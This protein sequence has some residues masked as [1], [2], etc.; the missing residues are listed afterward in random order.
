MTTSSRVH[1]ALAILGFLTMGC[2]SNPGTDAGMTGNDTGVP[3][4]ARNTGS[5]TGAMFDSGTDSGVS[6]DAGNDAGMSATPLASALRASDRAQCVCAA[7]PE[8]ATADVCANAVFGAVAGDPCY[9]M[10]AATIGGAIQTWWNCNRDAANALATCLTAAGA[11]A[12][13]DACYTAAE[14]AIAACGTEP[15]LAAYQTALDA[16][17]VTR[18][19]GTGADTCSATATPSS[20]VGMG[21]FTGTTL[22]RGA[23]A[24]ASCGAGE[25]G[26]SVTHRW[27]APADGEY[28]IDTAGS[29]FDTVLIVADGCGAAAKELGC[30]DDD[31][32]DSLLSTTSF[33]ATMGQSVQITVAGNSA[34]QAGAYSINISAL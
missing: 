17:F 24:T 13:P 7:F 29:E 1:A 20:M 9:D 16:C 21:V 22:S 18:V 34:G 5:E 23:H 10:T 33:A 32:G 27:V 12:A 4:D 31:L 15:D 3:I 14:A 11:C 28:Q 2:P 30:S 26:A 6:G 25:L 19:V 8:Y